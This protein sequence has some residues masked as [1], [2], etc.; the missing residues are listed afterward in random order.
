MTPPLTQTMTPTHDTLYHPIMTTSDTSSSLSWR[1]GE[2]TG[3]RRSLFST[4]LAFGRGRDST[5]ASVAGDQG[6][7][8][9]TSQGQ[10]LG[11][12]TDDPYH[13]DSSIHD[14]NSIVSGGSGLGSYAGEAKAKSKEPP[15]GLSLTLGDHALGLATYFADDYEERTVLDSLDR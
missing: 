5:N 7:G 3:G 14:H 9:G 8:P 6:P 15:R 10:G 2:K 4:S 11:N 13:M 12:H 1:S